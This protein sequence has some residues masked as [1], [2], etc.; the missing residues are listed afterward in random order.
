MLSDSVTCVMSVLSDG[1]TLIRWII[2]LAKEYRGYQA[3]C[4]LRSP[5]GWYCS[6]LDFNYFQ[7]EIYFTRA[8]TIRTPIIKYSCINTL[9]NS[10][11]MFILYPFI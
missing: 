3:R 7:L 6:V 5:S 9:T 4:K 1:G 11:S 10:M 2:W 8:K